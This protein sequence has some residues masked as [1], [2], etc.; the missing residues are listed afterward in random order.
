MTD[1]ILPDLLRAALER[2]ERGPYDPTG[3][4]TELGWCFPA[5]VAD[6]SGG[7][8]AGDGWDDLFGEWLYATPDDPDEHVLKLVHP[9]DRAA[10]LLQLPDDIC[11]DDALDL[12]QVEKRLLG[13]RP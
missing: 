7:Q 3:C 6:V 1:L 9:H 10:R 11:L 5:L 4:R 8:W 12:A 2:A 13:R